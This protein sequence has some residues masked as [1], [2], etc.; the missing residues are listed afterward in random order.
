MRSCWRAPLEL[1]DV[2]R[3]IADAAPSTN[4]QRRG[5]VV[6]LG[7]VRKP[8]A[9]QFFAIQFF[10]ELAD[11]GTARVRPGRGSGRRAMEHR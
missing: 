11:E 9:I 10:I 3:L 2:G 8:P 7:P 6:E 1:D 4:R 5:R